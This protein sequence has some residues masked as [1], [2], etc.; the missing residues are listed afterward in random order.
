MAK[1]ESDLILGFLTMLQWSIFPL[2]Y[3]KQNWSQSYKPRRILKIMLQ[4]TTLITQL[5]EGSQLIEPAV[6]QPLVFIIYLSST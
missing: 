6:I 5:I 1:Q 2:K 3:G 4:K